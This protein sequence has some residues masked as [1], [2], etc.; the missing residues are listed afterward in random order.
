[1]T[2]TMLKSWY[3]FFQ[4]I[5]IPIHLYH[6]ILVTAIE[7]IDQRKF[8]FN[9]TNKTSSLERFKRQSDPLDCS[10]I[11]SC[12]NKTLSCWNICDGTNDCLDQMDESL[13]ASQFLYEN[14]IPIDFQRNITTNNE[15]TCQEFHRKV[16]QFCENT[17]IEIIDKYIST[18]LPNTLP[19]RNYFW[20]CINQTKCLPYE[21]VC[22]GIEDCPNGSDESDE[23]CTVEFC[24]Q[25]RGMLKCPNKPLCIKKED[26]CN[27]FGP[28]NCESERWNNPD[29]CYDFCANNYM[30][31]KNS[32]IDV[33]SIGW[34]KGPTLLEL[35]AFTTSTPQIESLLH[36][37]GSLL[38]CPFEASKVSCVESTFC[39]GKNEDQRNFFVNNSKYWRCSSEKHQWIGKETVCDSYGIKNCPAGEDQSNVFCDDIEWYYIV[40]VSVSSVVFIFFLTWIT[41]KVTSKSYDACKKCVTKINPNRIQN[42]EMI[43]IFLTDFKSTFLDND[44]RKMLKKKSSIEPMKKTYEQIHSTGSIQDL[45]CYIRAKWPSVMSLKRLEEKLWARHIFYKT[46]YDWELNL[47]KNDY[48]SLLC[49][50][51]SKLGTSAESFALLD[52]KNPPTWITRISLIAS[53]LVDQ[54]PTKSKM[55]IPMIRIVAVI[56]DLIKD[57]LLF[58]YMFLKFESSE[59][60]YRSDQD[61]FILI[62][63]IVVIISA[64]F[65]IGIYV[66]YNRY[67]IFGICEHETPGHGKVLFTSLCLIFLPILFSL[68]TA[69][70]YLHKRSYDLRFKD[71]DED[72]IDYNTF[73]TLIYSRK[74]LNQKK[75]DGEITVKS[76]EGCLE[77]YWQLLIISILYCQP[78][79]DGILNQSLIGLDY[80][81]IDQKRAAFFILSYILAFFTY[82]WG[83]LKFIDHQQNHSVSIVGKIVLFIIYLLQTISSILLK[84]S[85]LALKNKFSIIIPW[86]VIG[87][88]I[89]MKI[90][91]LIMYISVRQKKFDRSVKMWTIFVIQNSVSPI[92]FG[93]FEGE[94]E[95]VQNYEETIVV[96]LV[97][98]MEL[99]VGSS[100]I[101]IYGTN[102]IMPFGFRIWHLWIAIHGLQLIC[103][104]F[105]CAFF[106]KLYIWKDLVNKEKLPNSNI[107]TVEVEYLTHFELYY[108]RVKSALFSKNAIFSMKI[109]LFLIYLV[110]IVLVLVLL[111]LSSP[112]S[113]SDCHE[114]LIANER[115]GLFQIELASLNKLTRCKDG[116]TQIQERNPNTG[117]QPFLFERSHKEYKEGF[118]YTQQEFWIGLDMIHELYHIGNSILRMEAKIQNQGE[119]WSE[120]EIKFYA[121]KQTLD[122]SLDNLEFDWSSIGNVSKF[123]AF[124]YL[125]QI[126]ASTGDDYLYTLV[127]PPQSELPPFS[128]PGGGNH[129]FDFPRGFVDLENDYNVACPYKNHGSWWY[130]LQF[131]YKDQVLCK[132]DINFD[133]NLNGVFSNEEDRNEIRIS[134]CNLTKYRNSCQ[135]DGY[136]DI[137]TFP[138]C[139]CL[140]NRG[141]GEYEWQRTWSYN[142]ETGSELGPPHGRTLPL[143]SV[144]LFL[145]HK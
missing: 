5:L 110:Y 1:M 88:C 51:R 122:T 89:C 56:F 21:L 123:Y 10:N 46:V 141:N 107:D 71:L 92:P 43:K 36:R 61:Y 41:K 98:F 54:L 33:T 28:S 17:P 14:L 48:Q 102:E 81:L 78:N 112:A 47:H 38:T 3:Y 65:L 108:S 82:A 23:V 19:G 63:T 27:K 87:L 101:A 66:F 15:P 16:E 37:K 128:R 104:S 124:E 136:F 143:E 68:M 115:N 34:A 77:S 137:E 113:Y 52:F 114:A 24:K 106:Y 32:T 120:F 129:Y 40:L 31:Y 62:L 58:Y 70:N 126:N 140:T 50:L 130:P 85:V 131:D 29:F 133:T 139:D 93:K 64:H 90:M 97:A 121:N 18:Y 53:V 91:L 103:A 84:V 118:G 30:E 75:C 20:K 55:F 144:K 145:K 127:R 138:L 67:S 9:D 119:I 105:W 45:H 94:A 111:I 79:F 116:A 49:C 2:A 35:Y 22:D 134:V 96:W 44:P 60:G 100:T 74:N 69:E 135:T 25:F 8:A 83:T 6:P 13:L 109:S 59:A 125:K 95:K 76:L 12:G 4:L 86:G 39:V 99:I 117:M 132:F 7:K 42:W 26:V 80:I 72:K 142:P 57:Y 11:A 73:Q